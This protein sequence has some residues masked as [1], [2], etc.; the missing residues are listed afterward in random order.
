M[1]LKNFLLVFFLCG[2]LPHGFAIT[3]YYMDSDSG[4]G[5]CQRQARDVYKEDSVFVNAWRDSDNRPVS[6]G[7]MCEIGFRSSQGGFIISVENLYIPQDSGAKLT[8][9]TGSEGPNNAWKVFNPGSSVTAQSYQNIHEYVLFVLERETDYRINYDFKISVRSLEVQ[10]F[11]ISIGAIIGIAI[12]A[13]ALVAILG[14][15]IYCC[16]CHG[17]RAHGV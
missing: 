10:Q 17:V 14:V 16:F 4:S 7:G 9:R 15:V 5:Q 12:G 6:L 2:V 1:E 13:V 8:I 11:T 3:N